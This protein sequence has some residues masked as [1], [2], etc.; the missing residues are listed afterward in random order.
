MMMI[1]FGNSWSDSWIRPI[2]SRLS[3]AA[4][5]NVS[6]PGFFS[7]LLICEK[8]NGF[9]HSRSI[10]NGAA[11]SATTAPSGKSGICR[12]CQIDRWIVVINHQET[13]RNAQNCHTS[14]MPGCRP[15]HR[16]RRGSL[17]GG[18]FAG[19]TRKSALLE[20]FSSSARRPKSQKRTKSV[21]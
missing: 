8:S 4:F 1:G 2:R 19:K 18:F 17:S 21:V 16:E 15:R 7:S 3:V 10:A 20:R 6:D 5:E 13:S 12:T 9:C 14:W 11:P